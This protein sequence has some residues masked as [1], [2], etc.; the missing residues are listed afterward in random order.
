[1]LFVG[2]RHG[3]NG[4]MNKKVSSAEDMMTLGFELGKQLKGGEV[5]ELIGDVGAGKTTFVKGL[6]KGMGV[7]D[8]VQSPTFTISRVYEG[9][10][11]LELH[12]YDFY[13]LNDAGV[14]QYEVQESID[15]LTA[16]TVIEWAETVEAV[17][18]SYRTIVRINSAEGEDERLVEIMRAKDGENR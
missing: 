10:N 2:Y 8:E 1:M 17:L 3:Y 7:K 9:N 6:A 12:H 15:N 14:M 16:V 18:P 4:Y 5:F 11:E 13:R